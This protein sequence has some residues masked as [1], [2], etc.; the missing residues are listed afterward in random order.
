MIGSLTAFAAE[1]RTI[2]IPVSMVEVIDAGRAIEYADLESP[3]GLRA[4]LRA[5]MIKSHRHVDAF[6]RAF[7]VF[8]LLGDDC[9][10]WLSFLFWLRYCDQR[11]PAVDL[12]LH[13]R[14]LLSRCHHL[15]RH[16]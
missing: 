3:S 2:G 1:L 9:D 8:F 12:C 7:D 13:D 6:D 11:F 15:C 16:H 10:H 14:H 5:T 4:A